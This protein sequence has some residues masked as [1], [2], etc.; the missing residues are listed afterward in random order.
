MYIYSAAVTYLRH[1]K[2]RPSFEPHVFGVDGFPNSSVE[3]R[4]IVL[5]NQFFASRTPRLALFQ[6]HSFSQKNYFKFFSPIRFSRT[7]IFVSSSCERFVS[8][9][10]EAI[11][12]WKSNFLFLFLLSP[13]SA[14]F[15]YV[16]PF[17]KLVD[18]ITRKLTSLI[19]FSGA[20]DRKNY[21]APK[22]VSNLKKKRKK[23]IHLTFVP[24][25]WLISETNETDWEKKSSQQ[26]IIVHSTNLY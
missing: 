16:F 1:P 11:K 13:F 3:T 17:S 20:Y 4:R 22:E 5:K 21:K 19:S 7:R 18:L 26:I 2:P 24:F 12:S 6:N 8:I 25:Y 15:T 14:F 9:I 10:L 23:K